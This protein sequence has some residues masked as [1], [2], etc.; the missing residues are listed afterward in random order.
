MTCSTCRGREGGTQNYNT[1]PFPGLEVT[2]VSFGIEK[3]TQHLTFS[4]LI[5]RLWLW[6]FPAGWPLF[7]RP[8][9][10]E[11]L[12]PASALSTPPGWSWACSP[13][14]SCP[15]P[16]LARRRSAPPLLPSPGWSGFDWG[17]LV[18]LVTIALQL[19]FS[20]RTFDAASFEVQFTYTMEGGALC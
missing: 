7:L 11:W 9:Y 17:F 4:N 1:T 3:P 13:G 10:L 12:R 20:L 2:G 5:F 19:K 8:R 14:S 6:L 16:W 18:D 15:S